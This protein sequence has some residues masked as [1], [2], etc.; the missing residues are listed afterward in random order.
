MINVNRIYLLLL[1]LISSVALASEPY[2]EV[3]EH[4]N[5][6]L[7]SGNME[8]DSWYKAAELLKEPLSQNASWAKFYA[9]YL[10][11]FG[12][13]GFPNDHDKADELETAAATEGFLPAM[14]AQA[15]RNEYGLSG[16][17]DLALAY[18]WYEKAAL[19]GSRS[20]AAR[21][22]EAYVKGELEV[23]ADPEAAAKW[24]AIK[25]KCKSP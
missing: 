24:K 8:H 19:A 3:R 25:G 17:I 4:I 1:V 9:A 10:Y 16:T 14:V 6:A 11:A 13:G 23:E 12:T 18:S 7:D 15:R 2:A 20:A 21:L 22:E 5:T